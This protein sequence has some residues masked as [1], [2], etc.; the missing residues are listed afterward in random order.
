M[1][2]AY[3]LSL[4]S[5]VVVGLGLVSCGPKVERPRLAT[6]GITQV[7]SETASALYQKADALAAR[8]KTSAAIKTYKKVA[9]Y[10]PLSKEA[11]PAR[12]KQA[13]LL[14]QDG[15]LVKS[16]DVYQQFIDKYKG[17]NLYS[18]ALQNQNEVAIAAATG[19]LKN[20]FLGLKTKI[21]ATTSNRMLEKVRDNAPYA[22]TAPKAQFAIGE[23]WQNRGLIDKS[24]AGYREVQR[25]YP[26]SGVAPEAM[27]RV[28]SLLM[29][30]ITSG[31]KNKASIEKARDVF[32]DLRQKY[33]NHKRSQDAKAKLAQLSS[34]QVTG[35]YEIAEY[36]RKRGQT[37]SAVYYYR[38]VL[39]KVKSGPLHAKAKA[40][41][42]ELGQ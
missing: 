25:R 38:E 24:I 18:K 14:Y 39:K 29:Q 42:A 7:N 33:P 13:T 21:A 23:L 3:T 19:K 26:D 41:L 4:V 5:S 20:N 6:G 15:D 40:R 2:K 22:S 12:Y 10:Y 8:G 36:Y 1:Q 16:F 34:R 31:D 37:A 32:L 27:Y 35:S 9:E 30:Q 28:G 17:S 11:A